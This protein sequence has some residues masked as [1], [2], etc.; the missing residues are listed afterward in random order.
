MMSINDSVMG[1]Q[2]LVSWPAEGRNIDIPGAAVVKP[3]TFDIARHVVIAPDGRR[4]VVATTDDTR[5]QKGYV[6]SVY[7][8]QS[9]YLTL[10]R[11]VVLEVTSQT[12]EEGIQRH[13]SVVQAIQNGKLN[14]LVKS[15]STH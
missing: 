7:P 5:L 12:A 10:L 15:A 1:E 2:S 6:T 9:D 11:L 3:H 8:Q 13:I 4:Y 14:D